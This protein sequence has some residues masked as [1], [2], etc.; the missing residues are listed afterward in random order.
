VTITAGNVTDAR[1]WGGPPV[2]TNPDDFLWFGDKISSCSRYNLTSDAAHVNTNIY[3]VRML[4]PGDQTVSQIRMCPTVLPVAG[5]CQVRI[6]RGFRQ[7]ML[8]QTINPTTSTFLYGGTAGD[9]HVSAIPATTFRA[10][11]TIVVAIAVSGTSTAP[12]LAM[13]AVTVTSGTNMSSL[14]NPI[15]RGFMTSGF[16]TNTMPTILNVLDGSWTKRDRVFWVA[17]A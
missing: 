9:E 8:F 11:E 5:T 6:F 13:N 16:K 10:G 2:I 12:S 1:Q 4:S 14:L 7:D 15:N 3:F 17:F